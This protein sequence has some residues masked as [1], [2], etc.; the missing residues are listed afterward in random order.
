MSSYDELELRTSR[1]NTTRQSSMYT[2]TRMD[3][4]TMM[5]YDPA[6]GNGGAGGSSAKKLSLSGRKRSY[7]TSRHAEIAGA[8]GV[9]GRV[10]NGGTV[11]A[12][13]E[14]FC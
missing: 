10:Q 3:T 7:I 12:Q 6:E 8:G 1:L 13:C 11:A 9:S 14:E 4:T 2:L 5:V